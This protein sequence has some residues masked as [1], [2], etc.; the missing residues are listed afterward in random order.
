MKY[1]KTS[2]VSIFIFSVLVILTSCDHSNIK[3]INQNNLKTESSAYL[4]QHAKNPIY[5]QRWDEKVYKNQKEFDKLTKQMESA[6]KS[7]KTKSVPSK[8][9]KRTGKKNKSVGGTRRK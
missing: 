4:L 6:L 7:R 1:C 2:F 9:R 3:N 8:S 5:W